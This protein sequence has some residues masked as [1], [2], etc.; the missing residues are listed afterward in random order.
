M[1]STGFVEPISGQKSKKR[2]NFVIQTTK[3]GPYYYRCVIPKDIQTFLEQKPEFRISLKTGLYCDAKRIAKE[4]DNYA[5]RLFYAVRIRQTAFPL[6]L[7]KEKLVDQLEQFLAPSTNLSYSTVENESQASIE[8]KKQVVKVRPGEGREKSLRNKVFDLVVGKMSVDEIG[9]YLRDK[10]YPE[11]KTG[12]VNSMNPLKTRA[13]FW[14][15]SRFRGKSQR[16]IPARLKKITDDFAKMIFD[17]YLAG[18]SEDEQRSW[19]VERGITEKKLQNVH[20]LTGFRQVLLSQVWEKTNILDLLTEA[21]DL[22]PRWRNQNP[23]INASQI[24]YHL[25]PEQVH[26][27]PPKDPFDGVRS[28]KEYPLLQNAWN[29]YCQE[30]LKPDTKKEYNASFT[31]FKVI[32]GNIP[33]DQI[34]QDK[35]SRFM[36]TLKVLPRG[37]KPAYTY[38]DVQILMEKVDYKRLAWGTKKNHYD[39]VK[40]FLTDWSEKNPEAP[41]KLGRFKNTEPTTPDDD[42][43]S[44][45][46]FSVDHITLIFNPTTYKNTVELEDSKY[47]IPLIGLF[48]GC[49]INEPCQ[50]QIADI[51]EFEGIWVFDFN[52]KTADPNHFKTGKPNFH[53]IIPVHPQLKKLG[54][55][56]F[57]EKM[58]AVEGRIRLFEELSKNSKNK[59]FRDI[60]DWFNRE[61]LLE[62]GVRSKENIGAKSGL[63]TFH[64]FRHNIK[65]MLN[66]RVTASVLDAYLGHSQGSKTKD[67]YTHE[68]VKDMYDLLIPQISFPDIDWEGLKKDWNK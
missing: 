21:V 27:L 18:L 33:M 44:R 9:V 31:A 22:G 67:G 16:I 58:K 45:E 50:L 38:S 36:C 25:P 10:R 20:H 57:Y 48:T 63:L 55:L 49:R 56:E 65:T 14:E 61:Y 23:I 29:D 59:Y 53:R 34:D 28:Q 37:I 62:I 8:M 24:S 47:W 64:S 68:M 52:R 7:I 6:S 39:R 5:K 42:E 13:E 1:G 43:A 41:I 60:D 17:D 3:G 66:A 40:A 30:S 54:F 12:F 32:I 15:F 26:A 46:K 11:S 2:I 51:Y 35:V 4:L 19:Y